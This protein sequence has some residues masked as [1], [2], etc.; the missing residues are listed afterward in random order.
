M[1]YSGNVPHGHDTSNLCCHDRVATDNGANILVC[2]D[3][4]TLIGSL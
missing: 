3:L 1:I 4:K 2:L